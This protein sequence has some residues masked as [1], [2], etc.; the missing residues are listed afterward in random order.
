MSTRKNVIGYQKR[1]ADYKKCFKVSSTT[2][3]TKSSYPSISEAASFVELRTSYLHRRSLT[4]VT[5]AILDKKY[6]I[7]S[8]AAIVMKEIKRIV[9]AKMNR[10]E[11]WKELS[12]ATYISRTAHAQ[13]YQCREI[14]RCWLFFMNRQKGIKERQKIQNW[15]PYNRTRSGWLIA[16]LESYA[17]NTQMIFP[18]FKVIT[19]I[20]YCLSAVAKYE[21]YWSLKNAPDYVHGNQYE[22]QK[23]PKI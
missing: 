2:R 7:K 12:A 9:D 11:Q 16:S 21:N 8:V 20:N 19:L 10:E 13:H 1:N 4:W 6:F 22:V 3:V 5:E 14:N 23:V 17:K 18:G 15:S